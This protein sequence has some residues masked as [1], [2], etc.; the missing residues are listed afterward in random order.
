MDKETC[1]RL[2][3]WMKGQEEINR[4]LMRL[5]LHLSDAMGIAAPECSRILERLESA[6]YQPVDE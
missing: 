2:I 6:F 1:D 4:E 5:I 3:A